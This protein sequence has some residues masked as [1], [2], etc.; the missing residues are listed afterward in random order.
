VQD[1]IKRVIGLPGDIV[2]INSGMIIINGEP[3]HE[4]YETRPPN[5]IK[6]G[7]VTVPPGEVFVLG[8]NRA[9]SQDSHVIGTVPLRNIEGRAEIIFWPPGRVGIISGGI[10]Q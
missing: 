2:E 3:I 4:S 1:Y 5:Y 8:D 10:Y 9:N 6:F 7:P